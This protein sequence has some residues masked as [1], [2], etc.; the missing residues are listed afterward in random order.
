[1][2]MPIENNDIKNTWYPE[3]NFNPR[4]KA[5]FGSDG[6]GNVYSESNIVE[7]IRVAHEFLADE[8]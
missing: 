3:L 4:F 2:S 5:T 1:M 8:T 6:T 7:L